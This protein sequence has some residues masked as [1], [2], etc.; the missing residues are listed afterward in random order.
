MRAYT[1]EDRDWN[2]YEIMQRAIEKARQDGD[3][4]IIGR[5]ALREIIIGITGA[6]TYACVRGYIN[7]LTARGFAV[8]RDENA[9]FVM[10][11]NWYASQHY[12]EHQGVLIIPK[13]E[14][15]QGETPEP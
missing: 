1:P 12:A 7:N 6:T 3:Y 5:S 11:A 9:Y 10:E 14:G 2:V 8:V 13:G 4:K 15:L